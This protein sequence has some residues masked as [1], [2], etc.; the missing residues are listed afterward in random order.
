MKVVYK[1]LNLISFCKPSTRA[2]IYATKES[3]G[4]NVMNVNFRKYGGSRKAYSKCNSILLPR[5]VYTPHLNEYM[6]RTVKKVKK[7]DCTRCFHWT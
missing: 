5:S 7:T 2:K 1:A 6:K 4:K 3:Q